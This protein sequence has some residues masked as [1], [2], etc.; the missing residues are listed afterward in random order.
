MIKVIDC[1]NQTADHLVDPQHKT[2]SRS[3]L[4]TY[5]NDAQRALCAKRPDV[6]SLSKVIGCESDTKQKIPPDGNR[7]LRAI[8]NKGG[9]AISHKTMEELDTHFRDWHSYP[10]TE[11]VRHYAF[12]DRDPTYFYLIP[13]PVSGHQ[14]EILYTRSPKDVKIDNFESDE[15][16]IDV[17]DSFNTAI[18]FYMSFRAYQK[19]LEDA[20][21]ASL[22]Q[23][24]YSNFINEISMASTADTA[25]SENG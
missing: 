15:S 17:P 8:R 2:W 22:S 1:I 11:D 21:S 7:F 6:Y 14:I 9:N 12:D 23:S 25:V 18:V 10:Q 5:F 19:G 20:F 4:L 13:R 16:F 24:N 3:E